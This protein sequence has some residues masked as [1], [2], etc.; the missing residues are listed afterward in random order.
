[1]IA[2]FGAGRQ[3]ECLIHALKKLGHSVVAVD[4]KFNEN[5]D[6]TMLTVDVTKSD[7]L[8]AVL[9]TFDVEL[10]ISC[11][12]YFLNEKVAQACID[13]NVPYFDLGGHVG[14]SAAINDYA[15]KR[16]GQ[17]FTDLG[18]APGW[19]NILAEECYNKLNQIDEVTE[20][21]MFC[22]GLP[23][24]D[25]N[26]PYSYISTWSTEG[27]INEYKD[28]CIVLDQGEELVV[29]GMS[30]LFNAFGDKYECFNTSGGAGKSIELMK[31]RGV[32]NCSYKTLRYHGHR[33][34]VRPLLDEPEV[35][36]KLFSPQSD[37][38]DKVI[39]AAQASSINR[40]YTIKHEVYDDSY[41]F[42][43]GGDRNFTA[44]QKCTAFPVASVVDQFVKQIMYRNYEVSFDYSCVDYDE[45]TKTLSGLLGI[46]L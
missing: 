24:Y 14:T 26:P 27:L 31:S 1:M 11:L 21:N 41:Y 37:I 17:V 34:A 2:V 35:L 42:L 13:K 46:E 15:V 29:N 44:M 4:Q 45:F 12:P 23:S 25:F 28:D 8:E 22:G 19:V 20:V 39:V 6:T 33:D 30:S 3:G 7:K 32:Q 16:N 18:L 40:N 43:E 36:E 5:V 9:E 38:A 10:A